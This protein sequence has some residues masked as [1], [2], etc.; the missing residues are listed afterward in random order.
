[1]NVYP[2]YT[3]SKT[4]LAYQQASYGAIDN[5]II[6]Y[7]TRYAFS[8][9]EHATNNPANA[10]KV[11]AA[12]LEDFSKEM[13]EG[14]IDSSD[15]SDNGKQQTLTFLIVYP[16]YKSSG[17]VVLS[18]GNIYLAYV[19]YPSALTDRTNLNK[20]LNSIIIK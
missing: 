9:G 5:D 6:Y 16:K 8:K 10:E 12:V 17:K 4:G 20:F 13:D 15:Y 7:V 3:D 1:M 18:N 11:L 14:I 19:E 2:I